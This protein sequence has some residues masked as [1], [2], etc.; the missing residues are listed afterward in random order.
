MIASRQN[1]MTAADKSERDGKK[2]KRGACV[3]VEG[4]LGG[5]WINWLST[6]KEEFLHGT[7]RQQLNEVCN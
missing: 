4:F 7:E 3:D 6:K 5:L 2:L 1:Q